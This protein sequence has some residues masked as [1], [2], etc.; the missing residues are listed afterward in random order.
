M[1]SQTNTHTLTYNQSH[2]NEIQ[3]IESYIFNHNQIQCVLICIKKG[4]FIIYF[5]IINKTKQTQKKNIYGIRR[6][7]SSFQYELQYIM[8]QVCDVLYFLRHKMHRLSCCNICAMIQ[9]IT[10]I[11]WAYWFVI[12]VLFGK[13]NRGENINIIT[14]RT[15]VRTE[16]NFIACVFHICFFFVFVWFC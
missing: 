14:G 7:W 12:T 1:Q 6:Q 15:L 4:T 2:Y 10:S 9:I 13:E 5:I 11:E 16:T 8:L 3:C